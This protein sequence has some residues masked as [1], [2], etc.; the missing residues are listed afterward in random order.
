[1][2]R[3]GLMTGGG[4]CPGLNAVIRAVVK[5]GEALGIEVVG[6][7]DAFRGLLDEGRNGWYRMDSER[8][9]GLLARGGTVLGTSNRANPF[10]YPVKENGVWVER[11]LSRL[12]VERLN[13]LGIEGLVI[14]GGDGSLDISR[15]LG[16]FGLETIGVPKTIDNDLSLTDQTFGFDTARNIAS[17][18]L[19]KLHTTAEAHDR[20]MILEVMGRNSGFIALES[21]LAGGAHV[22]LLP[23]IP[24]D[25]EAVVRKIRERMDR[26][27]TFSIVIVAE[28]ACPRG[29]IQA[30]EE[31]AKATP[32]RGVVRLGGAGK[33]LA[34]LIAARIEL[35]VRV[36]VLGHLQRGGSPSAFDRI[37]GT[38]MGAHAM[39]LVQENRWNRVV[40]LK[41]QDITDVELTAEVTTQKKVDPK[42]QLCEVARQIGV[43]LGE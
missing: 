12:A 35:E 1:M 21:G 7:E 17:D 37:L 8:S 29:G 2:R 23:E 22:I 4:D 15:R 36:T 26:G 19:D 40:V 43:S 10:I 18:A 31:S 25:P 16:A 20:V 33:Q 27:R 14:A 28:G 6:I 38:R 24:Y 42:G 41:G 5:R 11:D 34:D 3:I 13:A 9:A 39:T 30:V 32:G